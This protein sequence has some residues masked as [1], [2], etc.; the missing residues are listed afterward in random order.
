MVERISLESL[1]KIMHGKVSEPSTCLIKFYSN[2]C[3]YCH[4][5][6]PMYESLSESYE[7]LH[8]FVFNISDDKQKEVY[9]VEGVPTICLVR[10]GPKTS[11]KQLPEPPEPDAGT[12]Y[13]LPHIRKFINKEK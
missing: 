12:W 8:F 11:I 6:K 9:P 4:A 1:K 5:L 10:T 7:D 2:K 3:H 13:T